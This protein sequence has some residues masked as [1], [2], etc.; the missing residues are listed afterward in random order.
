MFRLATR[1]GNN[2]VF[3]KKLIVEVAFGRG[4]A[5]EDEDFE[6]GSL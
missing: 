1:L 3:D 2:K 5:L 4:L 6:I